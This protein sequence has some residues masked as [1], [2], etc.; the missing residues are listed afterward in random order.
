[1]EYAVWAPQDLKAAERLPIVIFLHGGGDE[2]DCFDEAGL[3]QYL[4]QALSEGRIPRT[5][6][7]VPQG[8][9][10]FWEN[11][12]DGSYGYRD[13]ALRE[14]LPQ[15][16][17]RY[18][19]LPCPDGCHIMGISMGGHGVLRF[20]LLEPEL[21]RSATAISAPILDTEAVL[22]FQDN[23]WWGWFIP[24]ERI[25]GVPDRAAIEKE[26]LYLRW[27]QPKDL[28]GI[29]LFISWGDDDREGIQFTNR[30]FAKH[31]QQQ[32]IDHNAFEYK[33]GHNWKAW[34][35]VIERALRTQVR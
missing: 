13:W 8:N 10:G 7:V 29:R 33:G 24:V 30:R 5:I 1:M 25:W 21:F 23:F 3:G 15:V 31:L 6:I 18:N 17:K 19:T 14:V 34:T 20:A 4:D 11:W 12:K 27:R 16:Q 28:K 32:G 22:N 2:A 35:P 26:D 9:H